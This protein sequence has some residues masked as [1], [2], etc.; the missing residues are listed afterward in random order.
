MI[1]K[2]TRKTVKELKELCKIYGIKG[3]SK[4][5]RTEL[6]ELLMN[7]TPTK[8][9]DRPLAAL[10][11]NELKARCKKLGLKG[12][13]KLRK[14]E[15]IKKIEELSEVKVEKITCKES[16]KEADETTNS[17]INKPI[18]FLLNDTSELSYPQLV[19]HTQTS[20][21]AIPCL[22]YIQLGTY[23]NTTEKFFK[24]RILAPSGKKAGMIK[25]MVQNL[26]EYYKTAYTTICTNTLECD[27]GNDEFEYLDGENA[28][29][30]ELIFKGIIKNCKMFKVLLKMVAIDLSISTFHI[31]STINTELVEKVVTVINTEETFYSLEFREDILEDWGHGKWGKGKKFWNIFHPAYKKR[32]NIVYA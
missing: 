13:S 9:A 16:I 4:L 22:A 6:I 10:N 15:L 19:I 1:T 7:F 18:N 11:V 8:E 14:A 20:I 17:K 27:W 26:L 25:S 30:E 28:Y 31:D 5:N 12:Y 23:P 29:G 2:T 32:L 3:Y 24:L 21:A